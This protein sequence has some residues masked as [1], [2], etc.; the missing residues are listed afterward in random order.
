MCSAEPGDINEARCKVC[1]VSLRAHQTD[2]QRHAKTK[3]H[4]NATKRLNPHQNKQSVL[5]PHIIEI[6]NEDK[7]KDLKLAVYIACHTPIRS[8]DHLSEILLKDF[9]HSNLKLHRTKCSGLIKNVISPVLL[10]ELLEDIGNSRYSLIVDESTDVSTTKYMCVCVRYFSTKKQQ[11]VSEYLGLIELESTKST[12]LYEYLKFFL[13]KMGLE[14]KNMIGIGTDGANNLCGCNH[15]LFT[16][17]KKENPNIQLIRCVCHSLDN[18][19]K[20]AA[21]SLPAN[22]DFLCS[23]VYNW[24]SYSAQK[25]SDYKKFFDLL[26]MN[27]DGSTKKFHK[28]VQLSQTRWLARFNVV[29]ILLEQWEELKLYFSEFI[30]KQKSYKARLIVEMLNDPS[31]LLL[32][33]ILKPL[34]LEVN[35]VNQIFQKNFLNIGRAHEDLETL[36]VFFASKIMKPLFVQNGLDQIVNSIDNDLAF[37]PLNKCDFGIEFY[38]KIQEST[39]TQEIIKNVHDRGFRFIKSLLSEMINRLP[40]SLEHFRKFKFLEPKVALNR[41][42]RP[43]FSDLPFLDCYVPKSQMSEMDSQWQKLLL[44]NWELTYGLESEMFQDI[45]TFWQKVYMH[46]DAGDNFVFRELANYVFVLLSMPSS[47]AIVE[48]VFSVMN[49]VKNRTRNKIQYSMLD[50]LL[51]IR[52]RMTFSE[53]C[54]KSFNPSKAMFQKFKSEIIYQK[55]INALETDELVIDTFEIVQEVLH[56]VTLH[57]I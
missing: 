27:H 16:L 32:L 22:I 9:G 15:S 45:Y 29:N 35:K 44:V 19:S 51:R 41:V 28:F 38:Q 4:I 40:T 23:E 46:Q 7:E 20:K 34:L 50:A 10:L 37:L 26:N 43:K 47:N 14:L 8:I 30:K 25:K 12:D 52:L 39:Y 24:F 48:R 5:E 57:I 13:V 33:V 49:A 2:L 36:I 31:N 11:V 42:N 55:N 21:E 17:L 1:K 18:A 54:C 3:Q 6:K 56:D 53:N